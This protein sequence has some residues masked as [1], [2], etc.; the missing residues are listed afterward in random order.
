MRKLSSSGAHLYMSKLEFLFDFIEKCLVQEAAASTRYSR[1]FRRR[2]RR[3]RAARPPRLYLC[4][5]RLPA[6][7]ATVSYASRIF[8]VHPRPSPRLS[9]SPVFFSLSLGLEHA[10]R[11]EQRTLRHTPT[12]MPVASKSSGEQIQRL[13]LS[14]ARTIVLAYPAPLSPPLAQQL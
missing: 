3:H 14:A 9:T 10:V 4:S 5:L 13:T 6:L 2:D 7:S 12:W 11:A 8:R 1:L